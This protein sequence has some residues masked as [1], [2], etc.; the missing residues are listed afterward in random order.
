MSLETTNQATKRLLVWSVGPVR[1]MAH[2]ALLGGIGT[3]DPGSL[4]SSFG[5]VPG[6]L[7]GDMCEIGRTHV[8]IHRS[9]FV[10]HGGNRKLFIGK[11]H[12]EMFSKA[13][14]HRPIDLLPY[15]P[16]QPLPAPAA[17]GRQLL[18]PLLFEAL[19]QLGLASSLLPI[20][21]HQP[22]LRLLRVTLVLMILPLSTW[23]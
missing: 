4:H 12:I 5:R 22:V 14:I 6:N 2:A 3:F 1:V 21:T 16:D 11:L 20:I 8:G 18:D 23:R 7:F 10:L 19:T 15:M 9:G 13:L 17:G